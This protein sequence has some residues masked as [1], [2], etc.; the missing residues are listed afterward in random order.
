MQTRPVVFVIIQLLCRWCP[1]VFP[2]LIFSICTHGKSTES[3]LICIFL[4]FLRAIHYKKGL[5]KFFVCFGANISCQMC[6]LV[7]V[8]DTPYRHFTPA[9]ITDA[10]TELCVLKNEVTFQNTT[11]N[12]NLKKKFILLVSFLHCIMLV[13]SSGA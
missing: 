11:S 10:L 1:C 8:L 7:T 4:Q 3:S 5:D 9:V 2:K 13:N 6:Q 12:G